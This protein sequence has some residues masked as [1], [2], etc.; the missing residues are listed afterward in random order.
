[1]KYERMTKVQLVDELANRGVV[2]YD[3]QDDKR[4][5]VQ[6]LREEDVYEEKYPTAYLKPTQGTWNGQTI[7]R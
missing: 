5:L 6:A 1:M 4:V 3:C 7:D 2:V